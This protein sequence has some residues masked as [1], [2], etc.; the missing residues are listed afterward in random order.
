MSKKIIPKLSYMAESNYVPI[1]P[2][3]KDLQTIT[4]DFWFKVSDDFKQLEG[5]C[6]DR[7]GK[8]LYLLEVFEGSIMKIDLTS[9]EL[10]EVFNAAGMNPASLKIH[11]DGRLFVCCLGDFKKG[12]V[13]AITPNG[14][15]FETIIPQ[16]A[17]FVVDDMVFDS[18]GGFYFTDFVGESCNPT[19]GVYYVSPDFKKI[20]PITKNMSG[21][22]GV[23]L[24]VN[25]QVLWITETNGGRLHMVELE[26]D[27]VTIPPFGTCVPYHF[28][29]SLG[30]DSCCIDS[31]DN[32]YIAMY[33]QGRVMVFNPNG[34][35]IGQVLIPGREKGH[36]L[37]T[38]HPMLIPGTDDLLIC[39]NDGPRGWGSS[40]FCAKGFAK[41]HKSFQFK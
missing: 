11:K 28:T 41:A 10:S 22:N 30:P 33:N 16:D 21:P 12:H 25:E 40:I 24:S 37:R 34:F 36:N 32:L 13:F 18:K 1:P 35:P 19:G 5:L 3:E 26:E 17:G 6:F 23:A 2:S 27:G 20:R 39:T 4:A 38:T 31:E 8:N 15:N 29:G 9:M 7:E 14:G